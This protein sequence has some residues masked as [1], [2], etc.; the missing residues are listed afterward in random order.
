MKICLHQVNFT[1]LPAR[2]FIE[3]ARSTG[4]SSVEMHPYETGE[5]LEQVVRAVD[6]SG[7]RVETVNPLPAWFH[8]GQQTVADD[9]RRLIEAASRLGAR[10]V[11]APSPIYV[12]GH[13]ERPSR[14]AVVDALEVLDQACQAAS[15]GLALEPVGASVKRPGGR[16][17]VDTV[18]EAERI[19]EQLPRRPALV[20]DTFCLATAGLTLETCDL[21]AADRI[22]CVQVADWD[23]RVTKRRFPGAGTLPLEAFAA[24]LKEGGYDGPISMEV[25][26][27]TPE[28]GAVGFARRTCDTLRRLTS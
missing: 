19:A 7:I 2:E 14:Q 3:L 8:P 11:V 22:A 25:F 4:A 6:D 21:P 5:S 18:E 20:I 15:C 17:A 10:W 23:G 28:S 24:R 16:G 26:P 13:E 1:H 9:G 12:P 27:M